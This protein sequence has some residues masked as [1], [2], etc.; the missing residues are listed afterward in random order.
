MSLM[1]KLLRR[2]QQNEQKEARSVDQ[3]VHDVATEKLTNEDEILVGL[4]RFGLTPVDLQSAIDEQKRRE[5]RGKL[6]A[7]KPATQKALD[8]ITTKELAAVETFKKLVRKRQEENDAFIAERNRLGGRLSQIEQSERLQRE[9]AP[10]DV[11]NHCQ[12]VG[13]EITRLTQRRGRLM[14]NLTKTRA[15]FYYTRPDGSSHCHTNI[16]GRWQQV[17]SEIKHAK[18]NSAPGDLKARLPAL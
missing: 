12:E 5:V 9:T 13:D 16:F 11:K 4:K 18:T 7:E 3:F 1:Q 15:H 10:S 14:D 8:A 17:V 6:I 2:Q